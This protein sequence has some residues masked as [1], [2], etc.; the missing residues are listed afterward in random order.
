MN[1]ADLILSADEIAILQ[2][3]LC[4]AARRKSIHG[5]ERLTIGLQGIRPDRPIHFA[6]AEIAVAKAA[7]SIV[8]KN[9]KPNRL[10]EAGQQAFH[11]VKAIIAAAAAE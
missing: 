4:E 10:D 1:K 6:A 2:T 9:G 5:L 8:S 3:V 11:R 7:L